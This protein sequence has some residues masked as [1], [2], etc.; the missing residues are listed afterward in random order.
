MNIE[1]WDS[2]VTLWRH[3]PPDQ[4]QKYFFLGNFSQIF[5]N[6]WSELA[7]LEMLKNFKMAAIL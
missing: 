1:G 6:F 3:R 5:P 2:E 7:Y 4:C